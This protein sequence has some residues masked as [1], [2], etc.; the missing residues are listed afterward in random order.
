MEEEV[1]I[2][3]V[4][5]EEVEI[6]EVVEEEVDIYLSVYFNISSR[7]W[8]IYRRWRWCWVEEVHLQPQLEARVA[9]RDFLW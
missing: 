9:E 6:E 1:E 7:K 8:W 3:E 2:E 5:I 4:K